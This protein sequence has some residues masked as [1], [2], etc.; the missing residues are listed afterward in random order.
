MLINVFPL[1]TIFSFPHLFPSVL[2]ALLSCQLPQFELFLSLVELHLFSKAFI[3]SAYLALLVGNFLRDIFLDCLFISRFGV[4]ER[5][6]TST[7]FTTDLFFCHL[8]N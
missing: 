2:D 8:F 3:V 1:I 6:S 5:F 7:R 4:L